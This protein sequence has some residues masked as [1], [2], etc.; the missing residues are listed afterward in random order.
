MAP[1]QI[2]PALGQAAEGLDA[3]P[4][5]AQALRAEGVRAPALSGLAAVLA[6]QLDAERWTG[7]MTAPKRRGTTRAA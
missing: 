3:V 4:L 2:G 5:L 1:D 6:G 7:T